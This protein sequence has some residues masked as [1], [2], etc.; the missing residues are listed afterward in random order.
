MVRTMHSA[1]TLRDC[2][3]VQARRSMLVLDCTDSNL[4]PLHRRIPELEVDAIR[5]WKNPDD[6]NDIGML[7]PWW[8]QVDDSG[9][10]VTLEFVQ[11]SVGTGF[12]AVTD[13]VLADHRRLTLA[14]KRGIGGLLSFDTYPGTL[15]FFGALQ[16][17]DRRS[18][19]GAD[20]TLPLNTVPVAISDLLIGP[21]GSPWSWQVGNTSY[22]TWPE[23]PIDRGKVIQLS[24][25]LRSSRV[26]PDAE[27]SIEVHE[28]KEY[29]KG[30]PPALS[31]RTAVA[32]DQGLHWRQQEMGMERLGRGIYV[33]GVRYHLPGD[34][35][36]LVRMGRV[37]LR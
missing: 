28:L 35:P 4:I 25:Q 21:E 11:G 1:G 30:G 5:V 10:P 17:R 13:S 18:T 8:W 16:Y 32:I 33:V 37:E 12:G 9:V 19:F 36:T 26:I 2:S 6:R 20:L 23:A 7:I 15:S 34:Q 14:G 3:H 31:M 29:A 22:P 27:L 24:W